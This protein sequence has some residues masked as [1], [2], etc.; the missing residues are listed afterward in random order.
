MRFI[1]SVTTF[2]SRAARPPAPGPT[3]FAVHAPPRRGCDPAARRCSAP[4]TLSSAAAPCA[5]TAPD[6]K[7]RQHQQGPV[8]QSAHTALTSRSLQGGEEESAP[9]RARGLRDGPPIRAPA[10][11]GSQ[12]RKPPQG[13]LLESL[14]PLPIPWPSTSR[15]PIC[16]SAHKLQSE[17]ILRNCPQTHL[18]IQPPLSTQP[19]SPPHSL[20]GTTWRLPPTQAHGANPLHPPSPTL[21]ESKLPT[22]PP[23]NPAQTTGQPQCAEAAD[24]GA[25]LLIRP[26]PREPHGDSSPTWRHSAPT[27]DPAPSE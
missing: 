17:L 19:T 23:A 8:A 1:S 13:E 3:G 6:Q 18:R 12:V 16:N 10:V 5:R 22:P 21:K 4:G 11:P 2:T 27:L 15:G 9:W 14:T 24:D 26:G 7:G 25:R 20:S